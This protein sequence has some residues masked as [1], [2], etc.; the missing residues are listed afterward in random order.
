M[1]LDLIF[2]LTHSIHWETLHLKQLCN[3]LH[4]QSTTAMSSC[5]HFSTVPCQHSLQS[6]G[7]SS[8]LLYSCQSHWPCASSHPLCHWFCFQWQACA[9]F[10]HGSPFLHIASLALVSHSPYAPVRSLHQMQKWAQKPSC[11]FPP[12]QEL[13]HTQVPVVSQ[14]SSTHKTWGS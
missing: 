7:G 4:A 9:A 12:H 14:G 13:G 6:T 8:N 1:H 5:M 11:I 2:H 10:L 3:S